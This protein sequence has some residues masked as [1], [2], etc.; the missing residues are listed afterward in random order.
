MVNTV[1]RVS[2]ICDEVYGSCSGANWRP[3]PFS[4]RSSRYLW[5]DAFGAI[6]YISL[7]AESGS[8]DK[9]R[10]LKQAEAVVASTINTLGKPF[11]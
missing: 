2:R 4:N 1:D 7:A 6:N 3:K 8:K 9:E 11:S 10:F 5:S